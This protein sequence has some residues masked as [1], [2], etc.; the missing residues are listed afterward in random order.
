MKALRDNL[1]VSKIK[2]ETKSESGLILTG[3]EAESLFQKGIVMSVGKDVELISVAD[4]VV[5]IKNQGAEIIDDGE[6]FLIVGN[7]H[8]VAKV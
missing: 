4:T 6:K 5:F 2:E 8:V 3:T 1:I 7:K